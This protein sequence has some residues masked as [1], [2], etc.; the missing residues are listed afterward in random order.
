M[1][2]SFTLIINILTAILT[3][4]LF[5][6]PD[7]SP[8]RFPIGSFLLFL[9]PVFILLNFI[10][11][12]IWLIKR[13]L[14]YALVSLVIILLGYKFIDRT[15]SYVKPKSEKSDF[16]VLNSNVRIFNVY[17]HLRDEN[18]HSSKEMLKWVRD[19]DADVAC[20]QEFY[21]SDTNPIFFTQKEIQKK[22][23]YVYFK[24][25]L[26]IR[27]QQFGMAIFSKYPIIKRGE[28]KFRSESNNQIIFV[29]VKIKKRLV[30]I[31]N[32]HL[33]SMSIDEN[34]IINSKFDD[35]SKNKWVTILL[36]YKNGSIQRARQ[37]K[38]LVSHIQ[39]CPHPVVV[40]GDLNEPP[41]GFVYEELSDL[42]DNSFQEAGRGLGVTYNG[43][44]PLLRIDNQFFGNGVEVLSHT[45]H[46]E[47]NYSDHYP[48]SA[49][50]KFTTP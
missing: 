4:L 1:K 27:K 49:R 46:K 47:M 2:V 14:H 10:F 23:S 34:D 29:D 43:K 50:Y 12:I 44:I 45:L 8:E 16:K 6:L 37:V 21:S 15:F 25:F 38:E 40:C 9:I 36:R 5:S 42:L 20:L 3:L 33:Q 11:V 32:I 31:Y 41:Y 39:A 17:D 28:I 7:I 48:I 26:A 30:R 24:P 19:F 13:P 22:Y 35:N 18:Y